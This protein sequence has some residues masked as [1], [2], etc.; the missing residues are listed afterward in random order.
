MEK[1]DAITRAA[2][3]DP[4]DNG[5]DCASFE[6]ALEGLPCIATCVRVCADA[7][8]DVRIVTPH[9][10]LPLRTCAITT[11]AIPIKATTI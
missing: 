3:G 4:P 1:I 6:G 11:Y 2:F 7:R 8:G 9:M 10:G 5:A